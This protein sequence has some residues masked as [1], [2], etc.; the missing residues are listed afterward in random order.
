MWYKH[1][2]TMLLPAIL[3]CWL[4]L[5]P[6]ADILS[7]Y[8][9]GTSIKRK[10]SRSVSL[11]M[12]M[13]LLSR[14]LKCHELPVNAGAILCL[15]PLLN[16]CPRYS[17]TGSMRNSELSVLRVSAGVTFPFSC[18]RPLRVLDVG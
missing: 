17:I 3:Y 16:P 8:S 14:L 9:S 10:H 18:T 6:A 13:P 11:R 4:L 2:T 7:I 5:M 1:A 15:P 12:R